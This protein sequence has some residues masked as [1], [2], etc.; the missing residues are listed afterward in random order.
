ML[1]AGHCVA[2]SK[3]NNDVFLPVSGRGD[4]LI[5]RVKYFLVG[6]NSNDYSFIE[7]D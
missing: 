1:T 4:V 5:G 3:G 2:Y 6:D 7:A